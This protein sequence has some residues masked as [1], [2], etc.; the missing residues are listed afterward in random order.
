MEQRV[1]R[2]MMRINRASSILSI[3]ITTSW[4]LYSIIRNINHGKHFL[5]MIVLVHIIA[6]VFYVA[7]IVDHLLIKVCLLFFVLK[8]VVVPRKR[9]SA[10]SNHKFLVVKWIILA[11][12]LILQGFLAVPLILSWR[13]YPFVELIHIRRLTISAT[14]DIRLLIALDAGS[15]R[16]HGLNAISHLRVLSFLA[17]WAS[18]LWLSSCCL[19][20][21][22]LFL[23]LHLLYLLSYVLLISLQ[24]R[25]F[26]K[27]TKDDIWTNSKFEFRILLCI[28]FLFRSCFML[29]HWRV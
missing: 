6:C 18:S 17:S 16:C 9:L 12:H 13:G 25:T 5:N 23:Y 21:L 14:N 4:F 10:Q 29:R 24:F 28:L 11:H 7:A 15:C 19:L 3:V 27:S 2:F 22:L 20:L 1:V 8:S 26:N